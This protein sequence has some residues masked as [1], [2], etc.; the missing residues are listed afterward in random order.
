MMIFKADKP[1]PQKRLV[2]HNLLVGSVNIDN[3]Q[4]RITVVNLMQLLKIQNKNFIK[5]KK[6]KLN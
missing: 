5:K 4:K 2:K 6:K 1:Y 3:V